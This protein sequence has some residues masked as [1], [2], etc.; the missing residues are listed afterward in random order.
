M[1]SFK[2]NILLSVSTGLLA[3]FAFP[4]ISLFFLMWFAFVPLFYAVFKTNKTKAVFFA[5]IAGY[6]F[7][8]QANIFLVKMIYSFA[9]VYVIAA[10]F[11][12]CFCAYFAVYWGIWGGV[13]AVLRKYF[14]NDAVFIILSSC[15][16][17]ILEYVRANILTGWPW[18]IVGY[19]QYE[20]PQI[21]QTAQYCGVYGISF[22]IMLVNGLLYFGIFGKKK[23]YV[24]AA[25]ILFAVLLIFG[26]YKYDKFENFGEEEYDVV[27][28]QSNVEQYKK[29]D[30]TYR[31]EMFLRLEKEAQEISK[32]K[33]DLVLWSESEI[34]NML[35][36][37]IE[38][39][40]LADNM[41]K[42]AGGFNIIGA[43]YF[44]GDG[45]LYNNLFYFDGS[46]GYVAMHSKNHLVPFG[47]YMPLRSFLLKHVSFV[48]QIDDLL[49][50]TD[51]NIFTDKKLYIGALICSENFYPSIVR[52]FILN[53][54]KVLTNHSNDAWYLNTSGPYKHFCANVFRA[55]ESRKY[56]L[57]AANTGV[58]AII[59]PSGK[60]SSQTKVY[61][62][63]LLA[64]K[65]RQNDYKTFYVLY[66][67]VFVKLSLFFLGVC[68]CAALYKRRRGLN[69]ENKTK[70]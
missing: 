21:I 8:A 54:A 25:A 22:A 35:P 33:K 7:N 45:K 61:E 29:L 56:V 31:D 23:P 19:S 48:D 28:V 66:G 60:I 18:L 10:I 52:R 43:H 12:L 9:E 2:K 46:G 42:T 67:D 51:S 3:A 53:G 44:T 38:S 70:L 41:A 24:A 16:W 1:L 36:I 30:N 4:K 15:V 50:G 27:V 32:I 49:K 13:C 6:V 47:E 58:S 68:V 65:F 63:K 17:V 11:Y 5:Y 20:F 14:A 57:A 59:E 62:K 34:I 69:N 37:D 40:N 26:I 64:G 55:V 39:Y